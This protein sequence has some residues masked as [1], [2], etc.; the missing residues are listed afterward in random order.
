MFTITLQCEGCGQVFERGAAKVARSQKLG[1]KFLLS[2]DEVIVFCKS[3]ASHA[4]K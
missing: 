2:D 1:R 4:E 3:V